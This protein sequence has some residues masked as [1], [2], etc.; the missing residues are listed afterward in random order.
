MLS[1]II[2]AGLW[3]QILAVET[4][5]ILLISSLFTSALTAAFGLG[6]GIIMLALLVNFLPVAVVI[7][8]HG[9]IQAGSNCSRALL[10]RK[11]IAWPIISQHRP[12]RIRQKLYVCIFIFIKFL[13]K[14]IY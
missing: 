11:Y 13:H 5:L 14:M 10:L 2:E 9:V 8:V 4:S 1:W 6:G 7:P 12:H 3:P